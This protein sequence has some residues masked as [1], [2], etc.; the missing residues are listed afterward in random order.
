MNHMSSN[1]NTWEYCRTIKVLSY[2]PAW[3]IPQCRQALTSRSP[4][5]VGDHVSSATL[6][7]TFHCSLG[8]I[9]RYFKDRLTTLSHT[10]TRLLWPTEL[11]C[12]LNNITSSLHLMTYSP[13]QRT[14]IG[15]HPGSQS[16]YMSHLCVTQRKLAEKERSFSH[17]HLR[18][19]MR[20][21]DF[22]NSLDL[23]W[24]LGCLGGIFCGE[25][26]EHLLILVFSMH[27]LCRG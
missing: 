4:F 6:F 24:A 17:V 15:S 23:A 5:A 16:F 1:A 9:S 19:R 25:G 14:D 3:Q 7:K 26:K 20:R 18:S 11:H 8:V 10:T 21:F 27:A 22:S 2:S 12:H 13:S